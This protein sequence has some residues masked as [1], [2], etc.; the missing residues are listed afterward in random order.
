MLFDTDENKFTKNKQTG[1]A[2]VGPCIVKGSER[3][4]QEEA[5][6]QQ[7]FIQTKDIYVS[8]THGANEHITSI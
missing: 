1:Q 5:Q 4:I 3:Y 7:L 6:M 2:R 8:N